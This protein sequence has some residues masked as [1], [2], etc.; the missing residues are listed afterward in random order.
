MIFKTV[1]STIERKYY[2]N[3]RE[4]RQQEVIIWKPKKEIKVKIRL[5]ENKQ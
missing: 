1:N 3:Q 4:Q 5:N 2:L